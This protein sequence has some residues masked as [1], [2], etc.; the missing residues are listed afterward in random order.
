MGVGVSA[1]GDVWI[2][3]GSD[4]RL[5]HFPGGRI[6][7]GQIV[8]VKGLKSP[9][10]IVIDSQNR[11]WVSN[12]QSDTVVRFPADDPS[13]VETFRAG[14]G[15]RALAL[16]SKGNVWVASNMSL[17][18]PPPQIPDGASI[19]KQFQIAGQHMVKELP[20]GKSTGV[21]NMIRPDGTQPVPAGFTGGGAIS[22]PW[23]LNIDGNDDVWVGNFWGR[24]VVLMAGAEPKGRSAESKTGDIIHVFQAAASRCSL[25]HRSTRPAT[26][27]PRTIGMSQRPRSTPS[28]PTPVR[29]GAVGRA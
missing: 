29:R 16:D 27:G 5:L 23:G 3:D 13:K 9:F 28:Q 11:V 20:P 12:S 10:D 22:V 4:N 1:K 2:A 24:S 17:D 19:M 15:V 6:K 14:I 7:D 21:I 18:F 8:K 26:S 25:T